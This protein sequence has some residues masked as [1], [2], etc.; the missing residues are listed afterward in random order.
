MQEHITD[1]AWLYASQ[2]RLDLQNLELMSDEEFWHYARERA[3]AI[4]GV[5][6]GEETRSPQYLECKL[7]CGTFL[8]SLQSVCAV[9]DAPRSFA[10][11]PDIPP[12]ML[13]IMIWRGQAIAVLDLN[14]GERV[15]LRQLLITEGVIPSNR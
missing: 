5:S 9:L 15:D 8:I 1:N 7:S 3:N 10:L 2:R 12:W 4:S 14:G 13:G 6:P 11:L